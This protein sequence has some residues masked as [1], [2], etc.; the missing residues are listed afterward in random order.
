MATSRPTAARKSA[1]PAKRA[2]DRATP[3]TAAPKA[4]DTEKNKKKGKKK[5]TG[6]DA[7]IGQLKQRAEKL[8]IKAR[9]S[10]LQLAGLR[11]LATLGDSEL[12]AAVKAAS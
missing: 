1:A 9:K 7:V 4:P 3:A 8:G 12:L 2:P 11:L 10:C 6:K 5:I